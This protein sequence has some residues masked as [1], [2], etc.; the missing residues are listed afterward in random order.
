MS[1]PKFVYVSYIRATPE[2]VW[3]A[4]TDPAF[5]RKYWFGIAIQSDWKV[6]APL[7]FVSSD[8]KVQDSGE[9][10]ICEPHR[11]LSYSW[12]VHFHE[13]FAREKPS[14]VTFELEPMGAE[15]KLTITHDAFEAG[16]KVF[17]GI[18]SGW[19]LVLGS[20]KSF[21]ETGWGL[22]ATKAERMEGA[23]QAALKRAQGETREVA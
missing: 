23:K 4:L 1:G 19:P 21:L 14:R 11:R 6:G 3:Q 16:S 13:I 17:D 8:G 20:L 10:L 18:S 2:R 15:V 9:V 12:S 22:D 7:R 5:T